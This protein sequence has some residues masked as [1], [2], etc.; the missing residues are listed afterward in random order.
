M[1]TECPLGVVDEVRVFTQEVTTHEFHDG[2]MG[3]VEQLSHCVNQ[4]CVG[5]FEH[6]FHRPTRG[7]SDGV[8]RHRVLVLNEVIEVI[9]YVRFE[10]GICDSAFT[11][12]ALRPR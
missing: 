8:E 10:R 12:K 1:V 3:F 5:T 11:I 9:G 2:R 7:L 6:Q 4:L